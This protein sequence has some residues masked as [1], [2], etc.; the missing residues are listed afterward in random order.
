MSRASAQ[1]GH[2]KA[3]ST[4]ELVPKKE[5]LQKILSMCSVLELPI[6]KPATVHFPP[7]R[8]FS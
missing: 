2:A 3:S 5:T 6:H 1:H 4:L 7:L 8:I